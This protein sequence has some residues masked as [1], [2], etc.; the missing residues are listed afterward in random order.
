[1]AHFGSPGKDVTRLAEQNGT[2]WNS[3]KDVTWL[4][5]QMR[6]FETLRKD[7]NPPAAAVAGPGSGG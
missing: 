4:V 1:M 6:R 7:V 3:K 5:R 2:L